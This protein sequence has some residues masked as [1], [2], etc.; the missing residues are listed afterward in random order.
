VRRAILVAAGLAAFIVAG[1]SGQAP[2]DRLWLAAWR[3]S[4]SAIQDTTSLR[5]IESAGIAGLKRHRDD[6]FGHLRLGYLS[7]R[8]FAISRDAAFANDAASEFQEATDLQPGWPVGWVGLAAAELGSVDALP[9]AMRR[10]QGFFGV[11]PYGP[12]EQFLL[13]AVRADPSDGEGVLELGNIALC[14][15]QQSHLDLVLHVTR[16]ASSTPAL[17]SRDLLLL[18]ARVER[19]VGSPDSALAIL[20]R[21]LARDSLD[22]DALLELGR[23]RFVVG[24]LAGAGPWF[25]GLALASGPT[26][27]RYRSD[28]ATVL[29]DSTLAAF[30]AAT[31]A[32]RGRVV[33]DYWESP[34]RNTMFT[35]AERL[36][37]HY[38]RLDYAHRTF[39]FDVQAGGETAPGDPGRL[40]RYD[41]RGPIYVRQGRY[42]DRTYITIT[43][44][45]RNESWVYDRNGPDELVFNFVKGPSDSGF[46]LV[47][48][49]MDIVAMSRPAQFIGRTN[50][51]SLLEGGQ[52]FTTYGAAW[53]ASVARDLIL[54]RVYLSDR[55]RHLA[56]ANPGNVLA[57]QREE[58]QAG[59]ADVQRGTSTEQWALRYELPLQA[60]VALAAV[61]GEGEVPPVQV[62]FALPGATLYPRSVPHGVGYWVHLRAMIRDTGGALVR[63]VDTNRVFVSRTEVP[64]SAELLGRLPI[65]LPAGRYDIRLA[66]ET[67]SRGVVLPSQPVLVPPVRAAGVTMSD[68]ALGTRSVPLAWAVG[69]DTAWLNP[70][71][72]F[73]ARQPL[74]LYFEVGG[75]QPGDRY[76]ME[77]SIRRS[78]GGSFLGLGG[79]QASMQLRADLMRG[80]GLDRIRR[81]IDATRLG[82]G[83]YRLEVVITTP[84][85]LRVSRNQDFTIIK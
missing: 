1:G 83:K 55:Y 76:S 65:T 36:R 35:V 67:E 56:G 38:Q 78:K 61:G 5:A 12:A 73:R 40:D 22:A 3:D 46:R 49:L 63:M 69:G 2:A 47:G 34:A 82:A 33:Q 68:L 85:G 13:R 10:V 41:E 80:R 62:A 66:I 81:E 79:T 54:S 59:E 20:E 18:R 29:P 74:E 37:E 17:A 84:D 51:D 50:L 21:L 9:E 75:L 45:P 77:L 30:D 42:Q 28:L 48:S 14:R 25:R 24:A 57:L 23:T 43:G 11:D 64:A 53:S 6:A 44:M 52:A 26:L 8:L 60:D 71:R 72:T 7:L 70:T 58:R 19:E 39:A 27:A 31:P 32:M 15:R 16:S 4:L